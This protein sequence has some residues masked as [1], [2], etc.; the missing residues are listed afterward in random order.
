M[1]P[2]NIAIDGHSSCGKS[3]LARGLAQNLG[4]IYIDSGAMYRAVTLYFLRHR[5][6]LDDPEQ[7]AGALQNIE[8]RFQHTPD[9]IQTILNG[10]NVESEIRQ[11]WVSESVSQVAAIPAVRR[12]LVS[13]QKAIGAQGGV[14]MDGRD[15]GTVVF[16]EAELKIFL[17]A[18][19][20]E[21]VQRRYEELKAKGQ[22]V[23]REEI[24][25]NIEERDFID[26]NRADSPLR[27]ASDALLLDNTSLTR[28][29][30]LDIALK[31]ARSRD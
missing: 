16:P 8:I 5:I 11:M 18:S 10:E 12:A 28:E 7:V 19:T 29:E 9:G 30:Q 3:T 17:T 24:R 14:V 2:I 15:I 20:D 23:D 13:Q 25:R 27:M 1:S 21:R 22:E 6:Q 26:S 4:F 31:W